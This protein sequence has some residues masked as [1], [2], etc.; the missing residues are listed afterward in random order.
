MKTALPTYWKIY[1]ALLVIF[2]SGSTLGY[3]TGQRSA[4]PVIALAAPVA[5]DEVIVEWAEK[6]LAGLD[7]T[8]ALTDEQVATLRP[9]LERTG[10]KVFHQRDRALFQISLEVLAVHDALLPYLDPEQQKKL[11]KS[12][13]NMHLSIESRFKALIDQSVGSPEGR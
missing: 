4:P 9:V 12:K 5:K 10:E 11:V 8:L 3:V 1:G 13:E 7:G 2:V 6:A